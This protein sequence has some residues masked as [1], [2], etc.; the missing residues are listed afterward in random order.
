MGLQIQQISDYGTTNPV[1]ARLSIQTKDLLQF[2]KLTK[3]D[4]RQIFRIMFADVQPKIMTCFRI[5][6]RIVQE[7]HAE[8][9]KIDEGRMEIQSGGRAYTLPSILDLRQDAEIFLYNGKSAL[10]DFGNTFRVLFG[11]DFKNE[12]RYDR[13]LD[14][15]KKKFGSE[16]VITK[17]LLDDQSWLQKIVKMRNAIEH[18]GGYSGILHIAN[19]TAKE[20]GKKILVTEPVWHLNSEPEA[21]IAYAMEVLV[22][23]LVGFCEEMLILC[24]QKVGPKFGSQVAI[25]EIPEAERDPSCPIR[26][27][28][29]ISR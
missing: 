23:N 9:K 25:A 1:V 13:I 3:D 10:R 14:W 21:P 22:G 2:Y 16:D 20:D 19:F 6:E 28:A 15:A 17:M 12:A 4:E 8:Q 26:F 27:R 7:V 18:P 29:V 5:K 24:L 11:K